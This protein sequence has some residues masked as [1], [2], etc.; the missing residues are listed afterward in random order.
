MKP[1]IRKQSAAGFT[2]IEVILSVSIFGV[3]GMGLTQGIHIA[4]STHESVSSQTG[5]N[6]DM[7]DSVSL[8]RDEFKT[9]Q[10]S[11][12]DVVPTDDGNHQL[13]F[14]VPVDSGIGTGWGAYDRKLGS[15]SAEW[16][17]VGWKICY[18]VRE[19]NQ[20]VS[21]LVRQIIDGGG[22]LQREIE[23][24]SNVL[25]NGQAEGPGFSVTE[26]GDVWEVSITTKAGDGHAARTETFQIQTRN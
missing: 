20:G 12:I 6:R 26:T 2:L 10:G 9:C 5:Y 7:R 18:V 14:Q 11:S 3:I 24:V 17:R 15:T 25:A 16:N 4:E 19:N 23:I 13:V 21:C 1:Y 8:L 22:D